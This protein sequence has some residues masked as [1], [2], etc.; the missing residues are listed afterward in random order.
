MRLERPLM[1]L[2]VQEPPPAPDAGDPIVVAPLPRPVVQALA[3]AGDKRYVVHLPVDA[4]DLPAALDLAAS[5]ARS[6]AFPPQVYVGE[7]AVSEEGNQRRRHRVFCDRL[8]P[9]HQRC[10]RRAEHEGPCLPG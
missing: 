3:A 7:A 5:I 1:T 10:G 6:L 2:C 4:P 9:G 8:L